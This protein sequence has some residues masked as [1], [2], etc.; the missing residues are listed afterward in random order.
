MFCVGGLTAFLTSGQERQT[1]NDGRRT[2]FCKKRRQCID[3]L[4]IGSR[5]QGTEC[6]HCPVFVIA[7]GNPG[8]SGAEITGEEDRHYFF[9]D[10]TRASIAFLLLAVFL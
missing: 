7:K 4:T 5:F 3:E 9:F 6:H 8:P 1:D 2:V 10:V